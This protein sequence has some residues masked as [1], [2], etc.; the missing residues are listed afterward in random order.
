MRRAYAEAICI[1][2]TS[3]CNTVHECTRESQMWH[4]A[5]DNGKAS[6]TSI[7]AGKHLACIYE[8]SAP[9]AAALPALGRPLTASAE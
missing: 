6:T 4:T 7:M 1:E 5:N 8:R 2:R 9:W 3:M